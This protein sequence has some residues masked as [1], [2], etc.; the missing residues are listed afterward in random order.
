MVKNVA[1]I[2]NLIAMAL[3]DND[4][5]EQEK[6]TIMKIAV[7]L[8]LSYKDIEDTF[9]EP[10][11]KIEVPLSLAERIQHLHDLVLVMMA[12]GIIHEEEIKYIALFT[13]V[14]GFKDIYDGQPI[15]IDTGKIKNELSYQKFIEEYR[16]TTAE[17]LSSVIVDQNCNIKFPLYR[18]ELSSIGPLP[19]TLYIFFLLSDKPVSIS[20]LSTPENK[21]I[22]RNIYAMMPNSDFAVEEKINNLTNPDGLSFNSNRSIIKRALTNTL[23][24][25]NPK[26]IDNYKI[27]GGRNQKKWISL[28]KNLIQIKPKIY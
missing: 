3:R 12:D 23:P 14:Y 10:I 2:F 27:G 25:D 6:K 28:P 18:K 21:E 26:I 16:Q 1:H 4:F 11:I 19:K 20:D 17:V 9:N 8:G 5:D 22:L 15:E 7:K 24:K 13:K